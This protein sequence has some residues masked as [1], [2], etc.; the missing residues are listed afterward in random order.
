MISRFIK[1]MLL[2]VIAGIVGAGCQK[3]EDIGGT[4][5]EKLAGEWW[6]QVSVDNTLIA[7]DYFP[8]MTYNTADN[9]ANKMWLDDKEAFW[10]F[11]VKCDVDQANLSF[12]ATAAESLYTNITVTLQNGKVLTGVSKGPVSGAVT[13]SIYFEAEFSDD[14]GT[15]YQFHGYAR[16]RFAEDDH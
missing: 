10:P 3:D 8:L 7:Q 12:S 5:V 15:V 2:L 6:V 13:D 14:P 16:T 4:A 11:K 1:Y 9:A